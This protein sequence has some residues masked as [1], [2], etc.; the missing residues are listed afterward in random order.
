LHISSVHKFE[1]TKKSTSCNI[2][3]CVL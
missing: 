1:D 2:H 3:D